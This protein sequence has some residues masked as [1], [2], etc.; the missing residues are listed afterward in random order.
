MPKSAESYLRSDQ[1]T[2]SIATIEIELA[3]QEAL[4]E[5]AQPFTTNQMIIL[6]YDHQHVPALLVLL[7]V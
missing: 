2:S 4:T 5:L 6:G 1:D 7:P 3:S